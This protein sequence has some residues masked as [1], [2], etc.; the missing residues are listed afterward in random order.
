[1]RKILKYVIY[2]VFRSKMVIGYTALLFALCSGLYYLGTGDSKT[3][4]SLLHIVLLVVPL[5]SIVFGT[6][7]YYNSREFIELLMAQPIRRRRILLGEYFG[8]S[9]SLATA[10]LIGL[11]IPILLWDMSE[12][13]FYLLTVAILLTF[14]FTALAF[15]A[16]VR[17]ADKARGIGSALL[18]WFYFSVLYDGI[19][20]WILSYFSDYPLEKAVLVLTAMNPIDLGRVLVL[21]KL[22]TSALMG[23]TGALYLKFFGSGAG[24]VYSFVLLLVW[25]VLPT[26]ISVRIFSKKD[27]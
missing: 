12:T 17:S 26:V 10:L 15:L 22:D 14:I 6:I 2:D 3:T 4:V 20:L 25:M 13:S 27:M 24:M 11:G 1:M 21:L 9:F 5:M 8:I 23:Y 18:M 7:H 16:S 19:V